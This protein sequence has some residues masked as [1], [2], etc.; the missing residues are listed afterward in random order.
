MGHALSS[1]FFIETSDPLSY[2]ARL[3][4][5]QLHFPFVHNEIMSFRI[6]AITHIFLISASV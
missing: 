1:T 2:T 6:E 4:L 3:T 5:S